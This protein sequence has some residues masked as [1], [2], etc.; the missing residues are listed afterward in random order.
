M[1][2]ADARQ[3]LSVGLGTPGRARPSLASMNLAR[4]AAVLW[5]FRTVTAA[6]IGFAIFFAVLAS[7]QV[8]STA[9]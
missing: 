3:C 8:R 4:H 6:G 7:Y 1:L 9:A 5:R 2:A